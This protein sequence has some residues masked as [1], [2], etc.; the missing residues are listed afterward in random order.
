MKNRIKMMAKNISK[1]D[2]ND[3]REAIKDNFT[4]Q[5]VRVV[6]NGKDALE[7]NMKEIQEVIQ[8]G[9]LQPVATFFENVKENF[10][11]SLERTKKTFSDEKD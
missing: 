3:L 5:K 9:C 10:E 4:I 8:D 7:I 11:Q 1:N 2:L 6:D